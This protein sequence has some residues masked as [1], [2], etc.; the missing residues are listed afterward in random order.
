MRNGKIIGALLVAAALTGGCLPHPL[1]THPNFE[2]SATATQNQPVFCTTIDDVTTCA[3]DVTVTVDNTG[4]APAQGPLTATFTDEFTTYNVGSGTCASGLPNGLSC[5]FTA[6]AT[7]DGSAPLD[8]VVTV[9]DG[10]TSA[11]ATFHLDT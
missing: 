3:Y 1:P 5:T 8:L 7:G 10:T 9:T 11:T 4:D 6:D 2:L